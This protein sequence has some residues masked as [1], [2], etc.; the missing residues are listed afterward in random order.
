MLGTLPL[1][2]E[3]LKKSQ[4]EKDNGK[5]N[6]LRIRLF[7]ES[8]P[9]ALPNLNDFKIN[10]TSLGIVERESRPYGG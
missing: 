2:K 1:L 4:R 9:A 8:G 6:S 7:I 3:K 5:A 10:Y